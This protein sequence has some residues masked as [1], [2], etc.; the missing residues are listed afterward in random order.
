[1]TNGMMRRA[2]RPMA[3]S[4]VRIASRPTGSRTASRIVTS[5]NTAPT[6]K[7]AANRCK[8][9]RTR[10]SMTVPP[11]PAPRSVCRAVISFSVSTRP[12]VGPHA[13]YAAATSASI[14]ASAARLSMS[15]PMV[16]TAS[17]RPS[18]L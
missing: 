13:R 17:V 14:A 1:M 18:C 15:R 10:W 4:T 3:L 8:V 9:T 5:K 16:T 6:K 11:T 12:L 7:I 2:R